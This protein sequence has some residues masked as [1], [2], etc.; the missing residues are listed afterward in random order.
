MTDLMTAFLRKD[1]LLL[2]S[3]NDTIWLCGGNIGKP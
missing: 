2:V 3:F 1:H